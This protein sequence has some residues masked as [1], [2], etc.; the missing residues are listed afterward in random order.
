MNKRQVN[1]YNMLLS[2]EYHLEENAEIWSSN[3][4]IS[5]AKTA[6]SAKIEEITEAAR[7]QQHTST[8][9]TK[10]K[11]SLRKDL[12]EKA[13]F[14]STALCAYIYLN[15]EHSQLY[16]AAYITKSKLLQFREADLLL[17][18][19]GLND[20]AVSVLGNLG[21]FGITEATIAGLMAARTAFY[22]MMN[23]PGDIADARKEATASVSALMQ[24]AIAI[25]DNNLDPIIRLIKA[26]VP[27]FVNVY[28]KDRKIHSIGTRTISLEILTLD[29]ANKTPLAEAQIEVVDH[30]IKRISSPKGKNKVQNLKEG[31]YTLSVSHP[32][33]VSQMIPFTIISGQTTQLVI[34][35]EGV[36]ET[37]SI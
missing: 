29:A 21:T 7:H 24:K 34:E 36:S 28:F 6:L 15:R 9:A 20:A 8:G 31:Y 27:D 26:E 23:T 1:Q 5:D 25:L 16:K 10:N 4:L 17:Y 35:L 19:E 30:H 14:I 2:V 12:E 33:F 32:D 18:V 11:K 3:I 13:L 22:D 37:L